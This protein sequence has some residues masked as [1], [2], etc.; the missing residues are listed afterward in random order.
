MSVH[1]LKPPQLGVNDDEV[2]VVKWLVAPGA[3]VTQG[4][5]V[6]SLETTKAV[7]ELESDKAGFLYPLVAELTMV[8]VGEA[9]ALIAPQADTKAVDNW[10]ASKAPSGEGANLPEGV[11]ATNKARALIAE[12]GIPHAALPKGRI[13]READVLALAAPGRRSDGG[14]TLDAARKVVIW[15]AGN[16]GVTVKETLAAMGGV[17]VAGFL[18]KSAEASRLL[19]GLPVWPES[20]LG[21]LAAKGIGGC[22]VAISDRKLRLECLEKARRA[23][24]QA[25][26]AIHPRAHISPSARLGGGNH[27]KA[28]AVIDTETVVGSGCII[29]NGAMVP[30]H[31]YI[32]DGVHI[33]PGAALGSSVRIGARTLVGI[34]A[35]LITG[36]KVGADVI[37]GAGAVVDTNVDDNSLV[38]APRAKIGPRAGG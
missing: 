13:L 17:E 36:I 8:K 31:N 10:K 3:Q 23:G 16:G 18:D 7:L 19:C 29:D 4:Q 27:I 1:E 25:V 9:L 32:A 20:E 11:Q 26:N 5:C 34:G 6:A 2:K 38:Q 21:G 14:A 30:H 12:L 15:G 35:T 28:G 33:A 37:I 24:L 22:I